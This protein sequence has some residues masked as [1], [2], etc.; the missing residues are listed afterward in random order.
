[1]L[2]LP[3]VALGLAV[4]VLGIRGDVTM[5]QGYGF[6]AIL[7][8]LVLHLAGWAWLRALA[9][10]LAFLVF[11]L[12]WPPFLMNQISFELKSLASHTSGIVL[13]GLGIPV[14]RQGAILYLTTGPLAVENP[15]SGLRSL[16]ALLA[17]GTLMARM[18]TVPVWKRVALFAAAWP[19]ALAANVARIVG[20]GLVATFVSLEVAVGTA[21]DVS[22]YLLFVVALGL[23]EIFRRLLRW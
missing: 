14:V 3:L 22:G 10:P 4:H 6:L 8:G 7:A 21:H 15:C 12:P 19:V 5:L 2:G 13:D 9:F 18:G 11:M 17:L 20:L 16:L 23:L 1:V